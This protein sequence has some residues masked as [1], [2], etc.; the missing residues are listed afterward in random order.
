MTALI[1][2]TSQNISLLGLAEGKQLVKSLFLE[3]RSTSLLPALKDFCDL[4]NLLYIAVG[5][6]PG[7]WMGVRTAATVAKTL[8]FALEIPLIE[9]ASPLAFLPT[10]EGS[11]TIVG[12][13]KM[14]QLY[15]LTGETKEG[16][17][18]N[19]SSPTLIAP[20]QFNSTSD[21]LCDLRKDPMPNFHWVCTYAHEQFIQ[22]NTIDANALKL[23]YLR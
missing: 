12:D 8:S 23:S 2:D 13:A 20:E 4:K 19:L 21:F 6:G 22:G 18:Q 1:L 11:F 9:F 17:V 5:T 16:K 15:V 3:G 14:G 7:S 10:Q